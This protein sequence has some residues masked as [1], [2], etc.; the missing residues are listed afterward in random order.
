MW[1]D[2]ISISTADA[3]VCVVAV[4]AR[5]R[6]HVDAGCA[7][8]IR[9]KKNVYSA[10]IV[11]VEGPFGAMDAVHIDCDGVPVARGLVNLSSEVRC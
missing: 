10:G 11:A 1:P 7:A 3:C 8:A 9:S 4:P 2:A 6:L 5:G